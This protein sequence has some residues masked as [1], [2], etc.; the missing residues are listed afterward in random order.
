MA[1]KH[2]KKCSTSLVT[3]E[4]QIKTTLRFYLIPIRIAKIKTTATVNAG[5][6]MKKRKYSALADGI[7]SWH[8]HSGNQSGG[9]LEN[10]KWFYLK[11]QL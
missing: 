5:K 2:L 6:E 1:K 3:R 4:M 10:W 11:T 8:N 7:S 9:S